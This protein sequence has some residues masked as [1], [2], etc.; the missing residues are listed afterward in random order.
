MDTELQQV[1]S[2]ESDA[3]G[4]RRSGEW[5]P[6]AIAAVAVVA[7]VIAALSFSRQ[8][9]TSPPFRFDITAI[10]ISSAAVHESGPYAVTARWTGPHLA[11]GTA[12][13]H[14]RVASWALAY[15]ALREGGPFAMA[16]SVKP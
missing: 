3:A 16:P 12:R 10:R 1:R 4:R 8:G 14:D 5:W 6:Y 2:I 7:V 9:E 11:E 13:P 15:T